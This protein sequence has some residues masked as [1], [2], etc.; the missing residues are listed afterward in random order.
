MKDSRAETLASG[1]LVV[2][3]AAAAIAR[4]DKV[5]DTAAPDRLGA[6]AV[7]ISRWLKSAQN[8]GLRQKSGTG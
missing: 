3:R 1:E 5:R 6:I 7:A 4:L 2:N 8:A